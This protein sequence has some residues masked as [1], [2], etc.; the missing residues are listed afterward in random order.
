MVR[1][2]TKVVMYFACP[3]GRNSSLGSTVVTDQ[4]GSTGFE[5]SSLTGQTG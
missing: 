4:T 5:V 1:V 2:V 3:Q